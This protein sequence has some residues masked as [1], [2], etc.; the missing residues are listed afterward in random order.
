MVHL[1]MRF[2]V[3]EKEEFLRVYKILTPKRKE[4]GCL[5]QICFEQKINPQIYTVFSEW[6]SR[7]D[8]DRFRKDNQGDY[9]NTYRPSYTEIYELD[10]LFQDVVNPEYSKDQ[11]HVFQRVSVENPE[12]FAERFESGYRKYNM[13]KRGVAS[14]DLFCNLYNNSIITMLGRWENLSSYE[15]WKNSDDRQMI[16]N[17]VQT[18]AKADNYE[19]SL[20]N[21]WEAGF[22]QINQ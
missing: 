3:N 18:K 6:P 9:R 20:I 2:I 7:E 12:S 21:Y 15:N 19:L 13:E 8:Y 10:R 5:R 14:V 16:T 17:E 11:I 1:L 22:K 4:Y